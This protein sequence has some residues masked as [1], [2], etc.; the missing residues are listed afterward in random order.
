MLIIMLLNLSLIYDVNTIVDCKIYNAYKSN[1]LC[2]NYFRKINLI[3]IYNNLGDIENAINENKNNISTNLINMN[4]NEN[5]IAYTL[6]EIKYIKNNMSKS[7]LKTFIIFY[8]MMKKHKSILEEYFL[9]KYL[10]LM[11]IKIILLK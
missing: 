3:S 8:F 4:G 1:F 11:L 2:I 5:N 10:M 7:Y 9:K 6:S